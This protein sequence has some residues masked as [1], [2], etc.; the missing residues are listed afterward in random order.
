MASKLF[1]RKGL[2]DWL[3]Q[4]LSAIIISIYFIFFILLYA[5]LRPKSSVEWISFFEPFGMKLATFLAFIA[6]FYHA[7]IGL[8]DIFTD[9]IKPVVLKLILKSIIILLLIFYTFWSFKIMFVLI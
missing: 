2:A 5:Y 9:Y 3:L 1:F 6:L 4:R 8:S 7:W